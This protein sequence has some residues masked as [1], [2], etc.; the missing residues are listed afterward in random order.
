[1]RINTISQRGRLNVIG[2][3]TFTLNGGN[4]SAR[5]QSYWTNFHLELI[6]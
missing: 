5:K 1:M 6:Y 2:V 3:Y 4:N